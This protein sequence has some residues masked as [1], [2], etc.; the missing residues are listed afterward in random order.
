MTQG[1]I[2]IAIDS[3]PMLFIFNRQTNALLLAF[4]S[5]A[6]YYVQQASGQQIGP[7]TEADVS[8]GLETG[9][10]S[11]NDLARSE[12]SDAWVPL[13]NFF[14]SS[15]SVLV[16]HPRSGHS[17]E[18]MPP[19]SNRSASRASRTNT[20]LPEDSPVRQGKGLGIF[21]AALLGVIAAIL[22]AWLQLAR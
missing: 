20:P 19:D 13:G 9:A 1:F 3:L 17:V 15:G 5:M 4:R 10:L 11:I 6:R 21:L 16:R 18:I 14:T 2:G 22:W 7:L 12:T 8:T